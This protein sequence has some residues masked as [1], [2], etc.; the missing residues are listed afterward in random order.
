MLE[1]TQ[2]HGG[3]SHF[4]LVFINFIG[5]RV[6]VCIVKDFVRAVR[7]EGERAADGLTLR[8]SVEILNAAECWRRA[9]RQLS[10]E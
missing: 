6:I 7:K 4:S 1:L 8:G 5:W 10:W 2:R 3:L 9:Y